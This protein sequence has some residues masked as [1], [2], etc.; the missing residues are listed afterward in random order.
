MIVS[1]RSPTRSSPSVPKAAAYGEFGSMQA[2]LSAPVMRKFLAVGSAG[3]NVGGV[4]V[5]GAAVVGAVE[6]S[7]CVPSGAVVGGTV[8]V[9]SGATASPAA[10]SPAAAAAGLVIS[11]VSRLRQSMYAPASPPAARKEITA[12]VTVKAMATR[13]GHVRPPSGARSRPPMRRRSYRR[14]GLGNRRPAASVTAGVAV[15]PA[16]DASDRAPARERAS[17]GLRGRGTQ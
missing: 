1:L 13:S 6:P 12:A 15:S 7:G 16:S 4:V 2:P 5:A 9:E 14:V 11:T 8:A 3:G 10:A 17:N